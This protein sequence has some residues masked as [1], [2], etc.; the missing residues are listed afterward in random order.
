MSGRA[1]SVAVENRVLVDAEF[2]ASAAKDVQVVVSG[3]QTAAKVIHEAMVQQKYSMATWSSHELN[4][5]NPDAS[6]V[7]WILTVDLLNFSFWSENF[8]SNDT[9]SPDTQRFA[10]EYHGKQFTGYWSLVAA[11]NRAVYEYGIPI[12]SPEYWAS[13]EFT[14]DVLRKVFASSTAEQVPLFDERYRVLKEAGRVIQNELLSQEQQQR[15]LV[16]STDIFDTASSTT[17][18]FI[19]L[20]ITRADKSAL[21]LVELV[22]TKFPSF[23]DTASYHGRTV[24]IMKR[25][26][27]L[28]ADIW[29]CFQGKSY[30]E[31]NDIDQITMFADYRVPQM[32][33]SLNC[34]SYSTDLTHHLTSHLPLDNGDPREVEIRACS[35]WSVEIIRREILAIDPSAPINSILIDYYLWDTAKAI[36]KQL[37]LDQHSMIACHRTRSVFY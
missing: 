10:V 17:N 12:T 37:G 5:K 31:F 33:H 15:K 6:T 8:D 2:V 28:V 14:E 19:D 3:C 4:P 26:Q 21:K 11:I 29:A 24:H 9:G 13:D 36:Q 25:A 34:I 27:I 16:S 1:G 7:N 32:L 22:S 23:C 20:F 18:A 30:G 35:I